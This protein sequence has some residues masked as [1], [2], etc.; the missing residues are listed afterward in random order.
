VAARQDASLRAELS[1]QLQRVVDAG[2][3]FVLKRCRYLQGVLSL[4]V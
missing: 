1:K 4:D 3:A 2:S